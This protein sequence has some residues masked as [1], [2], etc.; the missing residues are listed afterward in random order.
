MMAVDRA[1]QLA[2]HRAEFEF[3][4]REGLT[5]PQARARLAQKRWMEADARRSQC[6]REAPRL[7]SDRS[8]FWFQQGNMA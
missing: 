5:L 4:M 3:A 8:K 1:R 6:G 7:E 2:Q